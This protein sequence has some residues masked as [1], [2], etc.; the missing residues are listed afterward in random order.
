MNWQAGSN[1]FTS[2]SSV[3]SALWPLVET[4]TDCGEATILSNARPWFATTMSYTMG[5]GSTGMI[6]L[7]VPKKSELTEQVPE[8]GAVGK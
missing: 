7:S 3:R 1:S 4:M 2:A 5:N 6:S 8:R